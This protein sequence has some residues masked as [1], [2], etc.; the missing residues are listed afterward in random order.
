MRV[1]CS[2]T[3]GA[4]HL[5]PLVPFAQACRDRGEE[6]IVAVPHQ[7]RALVEAAG[8]ESAGFGDPP[9][10][11]LG[12]IFARAMAFL[13]EGDIEAGDRLVVGEVFGRIDAGA[14]LPELSALFDA[15]RPDVVVR[16]SAEFASALL[17]ERHAIPHV[18]AAV[19]LAGSERLAVEWA[20]EALA[21]HGERLGLARDPAAAVAA[22][23]VLT[24]SPAVLDGDAARAF[25]AVHR[26]R[27]DVAAP[28][29]TGTGVLVSFGSVAPTMG[30]FPSL[31]RA[32]IDAL[33]PLGV[34][35]LVTVGRDADPDAL[36]PLPAEVRVERWVPQR[37]A[38]RDAAAMV[39]HGG[40]GSMRTALLA[41]R[42][43]ALLPLFA[44][45]FANSRRVEELGAGIALAGGAAAAVQL[46]DAVGR[47]L[48]EPGFRAAA[49]RVAEEGRAL[50]PVGDAVTVLRELAA[51]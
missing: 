16:D 5:G 24:T 46:A 43:L 15:W 9:E 22:S 44:D 8:L 45:Q 17:A 34:P 1:L 49:E 40:F 28:G 37:E 2:S 30:F 35:V 42:P 50:A 23:P 3:R 11:E 14:A 33:V 38:M 31:Y 18:R 4:G 27:E 47:L 21:A 48:A 51:A 26:F 19:G 41:G 29:P 10:A 39:G 7:G 20:A 36:G 25:T 6:V 13:A 12:P 32:V